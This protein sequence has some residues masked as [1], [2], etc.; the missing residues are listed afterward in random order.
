MSAFTV[1]F[2]G[3]YTFLIPFTVSI[4]L[5]LASAISAFVFRRDMLSL[6]D[7]FSHTECI[8]LNKPFTITDFIA[9][10]KN[11]VSDASD[12]ARNIFGEE[13]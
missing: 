12:A 11:V 8:A 3:S 9:E 5:L 7:W 2:V 4:S 10:E 6:H 13:R 1:P